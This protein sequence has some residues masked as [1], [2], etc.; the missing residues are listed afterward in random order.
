M[1]T[2]NRLYVRGRLPLVAAIAVLFSGCTVQ[3]VNTPTPVGIS[4]QGVGMSLTASPEFLPRDGS[5]MSVITVK[6][7]DENGKPVQGFRVHLDATAGTLSATELPTGND[8]SAQITFIAPGLNVNVSTVRISARP[9]S[10]SSL[11]NANP[12]FVDILVTGPSIPSPAF[13]FEPVDA[14]VGDIVSFDASATRLGTATCGNNCTYS[15]DFGDGSSA[16]GVGAS[17]TFGSAGV[18]NVTLTATSLAGGTSASATRAVRI[19]IPDPPEAVLSINPSSPT[20]GQTIIFSSSSVVP[21]GV[22]IVRHVWELD[23]GSP[24][25]DTGSTSSYTLTGGYPA[26]TTHSVTLAI[27]DNYGRTSR[28]EPRTIDIP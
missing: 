25:V 10:S 12:R 23:N 22:S 13:T 16:T 21:P 8:G 1:I 24:A 7:F 3:E 14:A 11:Q 2:T 26:T 27:T 28:S 19:A 15:W 9:I 4:E 6:V 18:F 5:S 17:H 20:A